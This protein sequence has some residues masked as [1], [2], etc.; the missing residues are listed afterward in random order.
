[1]PRERARQRKHD[2][3][4]SVSPTAD[5]RVDLLLV[6]LL[7]AFLRLPV[8]LHAATDPIHPDAVHRKRARARDSCRSS[9]PHC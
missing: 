3:P 1:M 9:H 6:W 2:K 5:S 4:D 8:A 7:A